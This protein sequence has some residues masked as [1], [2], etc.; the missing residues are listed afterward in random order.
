[1]IQYT[2]VTSYRYIVILTN[3]YIKKHETILHIWDG[4]HVYLL[5]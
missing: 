4:V 1:M 2:N 3:W 5:L